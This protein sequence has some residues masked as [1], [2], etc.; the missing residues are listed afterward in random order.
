MIKVKQLKGKII[1]G[2]N[3][4]LKTIFFE[5]NKHSYIFIK[6]STSFSS[7]KVLNLNK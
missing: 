2:E 5:K 7:I 3:S 1:K 6:F 4:N